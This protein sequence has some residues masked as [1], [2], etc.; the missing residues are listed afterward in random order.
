[1]GVALALKKLDLALGA[2]PGLTTYTYGPIIHNPQVLDHYSRLGVK[3]TVR[4]EEIDTPALIIIRAHGIPRSVQ[5]ALTH[6]P[7]QVVDATCPKVKKAQ[8]L[9]AEQVKEGRTLLLFGER[10]HPEVQGLLSYAGDDAVVFES[11]EKLHGLELPPGKSYFLAAQ[12]TQDRIEFQ[13]IRNVLQERLG[14]NIP[15]LDTICDATRRRQAEAREIAGKVDLMV[16][17]GG[18]QSG[19]TRRLV[20]VV[21]DTGTTCIHVE[22]AAQI[23]PEKIDGAVRIGLTAGASTPKWV[24]DQ[25]ERTL[26]GTED[27]DE[28]HEYSS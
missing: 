12:T 4:L 20:Q 17:V 15:V 27:P 11:L 16:V 2:N 7:G 9:I 1:M 25:V 3:E 24:I 6:L 26:A 21:R 14:E 18:S 10:D 19:N 8:M 28:Q 23:P 22:S 13:A 5:E